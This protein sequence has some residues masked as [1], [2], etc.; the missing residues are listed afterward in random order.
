MARPKKRRNLKPRDASC[1]SASPDGDGLVSKPAPGPGVATSE[2]V[3]SSFTSSILFS[4]LPV[5]DRRAMSAFS[6]R[7]S[8][9]ED[10]LAPG[11]LA[12]A[13][14]VSA[15]AP[16]PASGD[17]PSAMLADD[18]F[19]DA[20]DAPA[21]SA[22]AVDAPSSGLGRSLTR[23][24][25]RVEAAA[26]SFA[27]FWCDVY[28]AVVATV[29]WVVLL[30]GRVVASVTAALRQG[31]EACRAAVR[32]WLRALRWAASH[33][34]LVL[35]QAFWSTIQWIA[36]LL[37]PWVYFLKRARRAEAY[38]AEV[39]QRLAQVEREFRRMRRA[40]AKAGG[41]ALYA[42]A[43]YQPDGG[44]FGASF[45]PSAGG[46]PPPAPPPL[47]FAG[48]AAPPPPPPPPPPGFGQ[49]RPGLTLTRASPRK[50][51]ARVD[52]AGGPPSVSIDMIRGVK[53]RSSAATP[54]VKGRLR[55]R[56]RSAPGGLAVSLDA[57]R[58][59]RLK[60]TFAKQASDEGAAA[61]T[62]GDA[63]ASAP[64]QATPAGRSVISA[65]GRPDWVSPRAALLTRGD[66][67]APAGAAGVAA[68]EPAADQSPML[69]LNALIQ[70][71]KL[72]NSPELG[73][74]HS[75]EWSES[76]SESAL[77]RAALLLAS[78]S[79]ID[80]HPV[81]PPAKVL[82]FTDGDGDGD[83]DTASN[84]GGGGGGGESTHAASAQ[85]VGQSEEGTFQEAPPLP[86]EP[87]VP[88][89]AC[90]SPVGSR[91]PPFCP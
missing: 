63:P 69:L 49:K 48:G 84:S 80:R 2:T 53:L 16:V 88:P 11:E 22:P 24:I 73:H 90:S 17:P 44:I 18:A 72:F 45:Q 6:L 32:R 81:D 70:R 46:A 9:G 71:A 21:G 10:E 4:P 23:A 82:I 26:R 12:R 8:D 14:P 36:F 50:P 47:P 34:S 57:L 89:A 77:T 83:G 68:S 42:G 25:I 7:Q 85:E 67:P 78:P 27:Q 74:I 60:S 15:P 62:A 37:F 20:R 86:A 56:E 65:E 61:P 91:L 33:W 3:P 39:E 43:A 30:P 5:A 35:N 66:V 38:I 51:R 54:P 29:V 87:I 31:V 79:P 55:P 1:T 40:Q 19:E 52:E 64:T 41:A 58:A 76:P 59:V 75:D 13:A 28:A